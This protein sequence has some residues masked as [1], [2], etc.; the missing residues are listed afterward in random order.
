VFFFTRK[1]SIPD[2]L[3]EKVLKE[4]ERKIGYR[5]KDLN[6]LNIALTHPS[7]LHEKQMSDRSHYERMEFLGD[8]VLSLAVCSHLY[9]KFPD[10]TEGSLSDIKSYVVSEK[11][12]ASVAIRMG[13]GKYIL[14]GSGE[15]GTGGRKKNSILA[16]VYESVLGAIFLDGGFEKAK[17]YILRFAA[18]DIIFHPPDREA[19]NFKG[20]LQ[21]VTQDHFGADP[22]YRVIAE[23]GPSHS[24][25]F[26]IEVWVKDVMLGKAKGRSKKYAEQQ[27]AKESMKYFDS[28]P[29]RHSSRSAAKGRRKGR[30]AVNG[31]EFEGG[32]GNGEATGSSNGGKGG[33]E[34]EISSEA[35]DNAEE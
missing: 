19:S 20:L 30:R 35:K 11:S 10:Y 25:T 34:N 1:L 21:K 23:S 18:E 12:L 29:E 9:E 2:P 4:F 31:I 24:P 32:S 15:A 3:R 17:E 33:T 8:S 13:L 14:F 26:E 28:H 27:A 5:F 6:L 7:Y 16:N 22:H